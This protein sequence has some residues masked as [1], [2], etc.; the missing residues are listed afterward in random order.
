MERTVNPR[1]GVIVVVAEVP[2][3]T[4]CKSGTTV[5]PAVNGTAITL[6]VGTL[7]VAVAANTATTEVVACTFTNVEV[8]AVVVANAMVPREVEAVSVASSKPA[9]GVMTKFTFAP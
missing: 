4:V 8:V 2:D 3:A 9:L 7:V 1:L 6:K 5:P